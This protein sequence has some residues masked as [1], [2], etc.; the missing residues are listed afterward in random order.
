MSGQQDRWDQPDPRESTLDLS[1]L[2]ERV[3]QQ[4]V[5][6]GNGKSNGG[7]RHR[8]GG[9]S[10]GGASNSGG[11]S[12]ASNGGSVSNGDGSGG[13][14]HRLADVAEPPH[15]PDSGLAEQHV[16]VGGPAEQPTAPPSQPAARLTPGSLADLRHRLENLPVGH[17]SSPYHD[18]GE[19]KPSPPRL[20]HL[21]LAPPSRDRT[22]GVVLA[23]PVPAT[24]PDAT[25]PVE[26]PARP[27]LRTLPSTSVTDEPATPTPRTLP[28]TSV[29]D[30]PATPTPRTLPNASIADD[31]A[32][33]SPAD[34]PDVGSDSSPAEPTPADPTPAERPSPGIGI[35][36]GLAI[37][38]ASVPEVSDSEPETADVVLAWQVPPATEEVSEPAS[39]GSSAAL[40]HDDSSAALSHDDS[41]AGLSES[42]SPSPSPGPAVTAELARVGGN[43]MTAPATAQAETDGSWR[44]G[45]ASLAPAQFRIAQEMYERFRA[46]EGRNLFGSYG[47]SGLTAALRRVEALLDHGRLAAD[48]EQYALLDPDRFMAELANMIRRYPDGPVEQLARRVTGALSYVFVF[49]TAHYSAATWLVHDLLRAQG[50]QLEARKNDWK[51]RLNRCVAT[52]W[53][54]PACDLPFQVQFHTTASMQA[55]ELA[56]NSATMISDPRLPPTEVASLRA[57]LAAAWAALSAPP[58]SSEIDDYRWRPR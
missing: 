41:S 39:D 18:D 55:Q 32:G 47:T 21:E 31:L 8:D 35:G 11:D 12:S 2:I 57:E 33:S 28:S 29:T 49:D 5:A 37:A 1:R 15:V 46:A 36:I 17:P 38:P 10:G 19:R 40:S 26:E 50:F 42:P 45:S 25:S 9:N 44:W 24:R 13:A 20:K 14:S 6:E 4:Q 51:N 52:M 22:G 56:R 54:D 53:L 27:T 58:G 23:R 7:A 16:F 48:T 43:E 3:H 34:I 30:E